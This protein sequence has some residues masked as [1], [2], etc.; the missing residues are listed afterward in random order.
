MTHQQLK[1]SSIIFYINRTLILFRMA[2]YSTKGVHFPGSFIARCNVLC[3]TSRM[4]PAEELSRLPPSCCL[5]CEYGSWNSNLEDAGHALRM[6][7]SQTGVRSLV[8]HGAVRP[9]LDSLPPDL[10]C[11]KKI[12]VCPCYFEFYVICTQIYS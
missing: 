5:E 6:A 3:G 8:F 2:I 12:N 7:N 11:M 10:L 9:A 1:D 4:A